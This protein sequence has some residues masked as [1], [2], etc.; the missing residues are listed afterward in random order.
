MRLWLLIQCQ[1]SPISAA[2]LS[3]LPAPQSQSQPPTLPALPATVPS[4]WSLADQSNLHHSSP[5]DRPTIAILYACSEQEHDSTHAHTRTHHVGSTA[6][7]A[8]TAHPLPTALQLLRSHVQPSRPIQLCPLH[9]LAHCESAS[10][11][12][13]ARRRGGRVR[14]ERNREQH[15]AGQRKCR[16]Q[17]QQRQQ[18]Q[19]RR[20]RRRKLSAAPLAVT[21]RRCQQRQQQWR[22]RACSWQQ[23]QQQ[24]Q[25]RSQRPRQRI[26]AALPFAEFY[27]GP[28]LLCRR[29]PAALAPCAFPIARSHPSSLPAARHTEAQLYGSPVS[30]AATAATSATPT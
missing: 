5:T 18:Q 10:A 16:S 20:R 1:S 28:S 27:S 3:L 4:S 13:G 21:P 12:T 24:Q 30:A 11:L 15:A 14:P 22:W 8:S 19:Q 17:Q 6:H 29:Q 25:E 26:A 23:Q 7:P 9:A 2:L